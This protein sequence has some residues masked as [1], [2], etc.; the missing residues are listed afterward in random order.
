MSIR[1]VAA[2]VALAL[3]AWTPQTAAASDRKGKKHAKHERA[4]Q[5]GDRDSDARAALDVRFGPVDVRL[6][7]THYAPRYRNLPPGLQ[8]KVARGGQLPPGWR[9]KFEPFPVRLEHELRPL[10]RGYRRGV[11]DGHAVIYDSRSHVIVDI[12]VLF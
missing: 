12:A 11:L 5:A 2:A 1:L 9:K 8:K 10:P 3:L 6:I 4:A 7:R